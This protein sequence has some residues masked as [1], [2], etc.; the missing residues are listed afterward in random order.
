MTLCI[1][2]SYLRNIMSGAKPASRMLVFMS[3]IMSNPSTLLSS[4]AAKQQEFNKKMR[5]AWAPSE[6]NRANWEYE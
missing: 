5:L 1:I 4:W 3:R 6:P 2:M